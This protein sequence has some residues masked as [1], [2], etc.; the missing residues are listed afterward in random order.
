MKNIVHIN[1]YHFK[2]ISIKI[3]NIKIRNNITL[4]ITNFLNAIYF[5]EYA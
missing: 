5:V 1:I 3:R 4:V 2:C